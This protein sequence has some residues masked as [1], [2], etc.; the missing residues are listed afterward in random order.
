MSN[1]D[2]EE[3]IQNCENLEKVI[4]ELIQEYE[5]TPQGQKRKL[6]NEIESKIKSL[7]TDLDFIDCE[8]TEMQ[9][10]KVK[11]EY[12][13]KYN[14]HKQTVQ[15]LENALAMIVK[16]KEEQNKNV[17]ANQLMGQA[18]SL[19]QQQQSSLQQTIGYAQVALG[20]GSA[21]IEEIKRQQDQ[22]NKMDK[23]LDKLN[24]ELDVA[25]VYLKQM[26]GRGAGDNCIRVLIILVLLCIIGVIVTEIVAPGT[27]KNQVEKGFTTEG[28]ASNQTEI[29]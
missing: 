6:Q 16:P 17:S 28:S 5:D 25:K 15:E 11:D 20:A 19:Q 3:S 18:I 4:E 22:M 9:D 13:E 27:I 8:I 7:K 26:V 2:I 10:G 29:N 14:T 12:T 1:E 24:S 21:S 23:N